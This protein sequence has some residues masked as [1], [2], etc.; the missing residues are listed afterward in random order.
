MHGFDV[1]R[2]VQERTPIWTRLEQL[3]RRVEHAGLRSLDL[4]GRARAEQAVSRGLER[5]DPRA[6]RA[7]QRQRRRLPE[8]H[9]RARLRG[10]AHGTRVSAE[11]RVLDFLLRGFPRL[12]RA[13]GARSRWPRRSCSRARRRRGVRRR[14]PALARR[15]DPGHHQQL[16]PGERVGRD[17]HGHSAAGPIRPPAFSGWLFTHNIE[18]SFVGVRARHHLRRSA[19]SRC[20]ST[21]ACRSARSRCSTTRAASAR[22]SGRGSCRTAFRS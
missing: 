19:R 7:G 22:S 14:R 5:P 2:F 4:R 15:A 8:R 17:E 21:T 18:V 6:H 13:S 16:T 10:G 3:L 20:C 11:R 12:F 1:N 9:R